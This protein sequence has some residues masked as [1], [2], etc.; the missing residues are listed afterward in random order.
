MTVM[1]MIMMLTVSFTF[2][3]ADVDG[4]RT[5]KERQRVIDSWPRCCVGGVSRWGGRSWGGRAQLRN[6]EEARHPHQRRTTKAPEGT[7]AQGAGHSF[8]PS[9]SWIC[10]CFTLSVA[11]GSKGLASRY[12]NVRPMVPQK[13][14]AS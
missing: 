14:S 2:A 1:T 10:A 9:K 3:F 6:T 13:S 5:A 12:G 8:N 4:V 7:R 11:L